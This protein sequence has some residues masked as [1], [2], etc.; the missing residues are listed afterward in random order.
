M[1]TKQESSRWERNLRA[2]V[3]SAGANDPEAFAELVALAEWLEHVGLHRAYEQLR[4]NGYSTR[5]IARP[6]NC[7]HQ[8]AFAR[9]ASR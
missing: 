3:G 9:F 2:M 5:E 6:L 8:A 1:W 4:E 7:S